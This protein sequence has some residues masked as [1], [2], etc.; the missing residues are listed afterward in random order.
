MCGFIDFNKTFG[1]FFGIDRY[2]LFDF[3]STVAIPA[4]FI[5]LFIFFINSIT[6]NT[7]IKT[8]K[9]KL[10]NLN[11]RKNKYKIYFND[12]IDLSLSLFNFNRPSV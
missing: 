2:N 8:R 6:T 10:N 12:F 3:D 7:T 5:Y 4:L 9:K 1:G 11:T